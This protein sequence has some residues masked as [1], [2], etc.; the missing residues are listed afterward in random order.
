VQIFPSRD[1]P[2]TVLEVS[3]FTIKIVYIVSA[4]ATPAASNCINDVGCGDAGG[5]ENAAQLNQQC[6][7]RSIVFGEHEEPQGQA[8]GTQDY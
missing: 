7:Q 2:L 6:C 8:D 1:D 4:L 3:L 5:K